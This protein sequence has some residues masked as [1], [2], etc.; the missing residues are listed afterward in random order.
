MAFVNEKYQKFIYHV[1]SKKHC[2][3]VLHDFCLSNFSILFQANF[4]WHQL[5]I[6]ENLLKKNYATHCLNHDKDKL[7]KFCQEKY[8][9][10]HDLTSINW[11]DYSSWH[12]ASNSPPSIS[13]HF[14]HSL[15]ETRYFIK[16]YWQLFWYGLICQKS[17]LG[18]LEQQFQ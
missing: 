12:L 15:K 18:G 17:L 1:F 5:K 6:T 16:G 11:F 7:D 8:A 3:I 9:L 14:A 10:W 2:F 13:K 4:S